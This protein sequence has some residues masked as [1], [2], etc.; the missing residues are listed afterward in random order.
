MVAQ[1]DSAFIKK[2][3][4]KVWSRLVAYLAFEGRPLTTRG[5]WINSAVFFGYGLWAR[6]PL[7]RPTKPPIFIMGVGRSGTTILGKI[8]ALHRDLGYL[9]EPKAL[10]QAALR[11][12]DL[13]GSYSSQPGRYRMTGRD[14]TAKKEQR[15]TRF[16]K[17]YQ[18]LSVSKRTVDKYPELLFRAGLIERI[19]PGAPMILLTRSGTDICRSVETWSDQHG[20]TQADWWGR[21]GQK[22]QLLVD[23]LVRPDPR[24]AGL[25]AAAEQMS[26]QT[27]RAALEWIVSMSEAEELLASGHHNMLMVRYED[28]VD[29]PHGTLH[30]I[31][32]H[33]GLPP[34]TAMLNYASTVLR[35][36]SPHPPPRLHPALADWFAQTMERLGYQDR[37]AA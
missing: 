12:D 35:A 29:D 37:T 3:P 10:W 36:A 27:D 22:W 19:F 5:R 4:W 8:L 1:L 17:A 25:A 33:C 31:C 26:G 11:D 9:N 23:Q 24:F 16:Y 32:S 20:D 15:L 28:L 21:D 34:D 6:L 14:V 2:R 7:G 13:I 18:F 30:Q